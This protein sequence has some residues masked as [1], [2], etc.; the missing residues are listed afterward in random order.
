MP[1]R[2]VLVGGVEL[3]SDTQGLRFLRDNDRHWAIPRFTQALARAAAKVAAERP[4][5]PPLTIGDLSVKTGGELMPHFSHRSGRDAD[6]LL[7]MTTLDGVPV[8]SPGFVHVGP[9]GL[10][11]DEAHA[12]FLR[13][14]V[15][16]EWLLVKALVEDDDARVQ[17]I[18]S[19]HVV[20]AL[21]VE[22]AIA[23]GESSDTVLRAVRVMLEPNPG[24]AH[25]D[26]VHVRTACTQEEIASGCE[27]TGPSREWLD[28][29]AD[30]GVGD[31]NEELVVELLRP[32]EPPASISMAP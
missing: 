8:E 23:R 12:R 29:P 6:L 20:E 11:W 15:E 14:D 24:G 18:F 9:D 31:S 26:H 32:L 17:W 25:D 21:V 22:W 2:G 30:A 5:S 28:G 4:G 27:H 10:A 13:L 16:R 1:H 19:N 7:Y 3:S